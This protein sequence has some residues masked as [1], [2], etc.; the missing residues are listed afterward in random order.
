MTPEIRNILTELGQATADELA[1]RLQI[2]TFAG[3][4]Q[5]R[6]ALGDLAKRG[7]VIRE[8]RPALYRLADLGGGRYGKQ[9]A[10]WRAVQ[11]EHLGF[12]YKKIMLLAGTC[13]DY[14]RRYLR[15]LERQGYVVKTGKTP[16]Q[17]AN[18]RCEVV[19]RLVPGKE[20]V[21]APHWARVKEERK[22]SSKFKVQSS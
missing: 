22:D 6:D 15:W 13:H 14:T 9:E 17:K 3:L 10:I 12:T 19:L 21:T 1:E 11:V 4:K 7:Q 16:R 18:E 8:E 2:Q 20:R 5:L